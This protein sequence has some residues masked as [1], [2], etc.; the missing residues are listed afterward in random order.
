MDKSGQASSPIMGKDAALQQG[1]SPLD[2]G[3]P[4]FPNVMKVFYARPH[5]K[6]LNLCGE[7]ESDVHFAISIYRGISAAPPLGERPGLLLHSGPRAEDPLLAAATRW[8]A[9]RMRPDAVQHSL[10]SQILLPSLS[11]AGSDGSFVGDTVLEPMQGYTSKAGQVA[12]GFAIEVEDGGQL[13]REDFEWRKIE[14]GVNGAF[15]LIRLGRPGSITHDVDVTLSF[16]K[17]VHGGM[18]SWL[19][20][21]HYQYCT[22]TGVADG[23]AAGLGQR[24]ALMVVMSA[25]WLNQ[26]RFAGFTDEKHVRREEARYGNKRV[27]VDM[28]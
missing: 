9:Q 3:A 21:Q 7:D 11:T 17:R 6:R 28:D 4:T 1:L 15:R 23:I 25:I 26:D 22:L 16:T 19:F 2:A 20:G 13:N 24:W 8:S 12:F 14:P 10:A 27:A 18:T 5:L